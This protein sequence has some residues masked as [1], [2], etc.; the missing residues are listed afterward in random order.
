VNLSGTAAETIDTALLIP[1]SL[2]PNGVIDIAKMLDDAAGGL[3]FGQDKPRQDYEEFLAECRRREQEMQPTVEKIVNEIISLADTISTPLHASQLLGE[4]VGK[5][6]VQAS[7]TDARIDPR[8]FGT[9]S[10]WHITYAREQIAAGNYEQAH[11]A[12]HLAVLAD[13]ST[14][15]PGGVKRNR[16]I[17]GG[18]PDMLD[19]A[20][21]RLS[22]DAEKIE[23][24][25][26]VS[27]ECP[28]CHAK[29]V[30]T[31]SKGGVFYGAC[32]CDSVHGKKVSTSTEKKSNAKTT[33]PD[34][35]AQIIS[36]LS[37]SMQTKPNVS[38]KP[39]AKVA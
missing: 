35:G 11:Q 28:M 12:T 24:C 22:D 36:I 4:V 15:C 25:D 16:G 10:A 29:N 1:K 30:K 23:D 6:M 9:E 2:M 7:V 38:Q 37:K 19:E 27:K 13:T 8:V 17:E 20:S 33:A 34:Y 31:T 5:Y 14:S 3:F 39:L 21:G 26:F 32:G 18:I